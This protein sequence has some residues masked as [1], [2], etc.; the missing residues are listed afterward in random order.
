VLARAALEIH[1]HR[2]ARSAEETRKRARFEGSHPEVG[3]IDI[4]ARPTD[5]HDIP[6]LRAVAEGLRPSAPGTL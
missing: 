4:A 6:G 3:V 2:L 5:V 1:T